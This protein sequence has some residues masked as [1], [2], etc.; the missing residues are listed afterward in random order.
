MRKIIGCWL[1]ATFSIMLHVAVQAQGLESPQA[2]G[3]L[4]RNA[5]IKGDSTLLAPAIIST[6]YAVAAER[7]RFRAE[8]SGNPSLKL[9]SLFATPSFEGKMIRNAEAARGHFYEMFDWLMQ[10]SNDAGLN[11]KKDDRLYVL[12][13]PKALHGFKREGIILLFYKLRGA[14]VMPFRIDFVETEDGRFFIARVQGYN[15]SRATRAVDGY[16]QSQHK[17]KKYSVSA[18]GNFNVDDEGHLKQY[19]FT[20]RYLLDGEP[21]EQTF[22]LNDQFKVLDTHTPTEA[23]AFDRYPAPYPDLLWLNCKRLPIEKYRPTETAAEARRKA[24][25]QRIARGSNTFIMAKQYL[26]DGDSANAMKGAYKALDFFQEA[27]PF[28]ATMPEAYFKSGE[29]LHLL[30]N[31]PQSCAYLRKAQSLGM[32]SPKLDSLLSSCPQDTTAAPQSEP[33]S[34]EAQAPAEPAAPESAEEAAQEADEA[35]PAAPAAVPAAMENAAAPAD[36]LPAVPADSM[37]LPPAPQADSV[38]VEEPD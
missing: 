8:L 33:S 13:S 16:L 15:W 27:I 34:T 22:V 31:E 12:A 14:E 30:Q 28:A 5:M 21:F 20:Q 11:W 4:F 32:E 10:R 3:K 29:V 38:G 25:F 19:L 7:N 26:A 24:Y 9:D 2:L 35:A 23:D 6:D 36:S 17:G 18:Y 1:L 37:P